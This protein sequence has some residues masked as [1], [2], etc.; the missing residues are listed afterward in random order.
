MTVH[1]H[2][3]NTDSA[4]PQRRTQT[5]RPRRAQARGRLLLHHSPSHS[6]GR[7]PSV[8]VG[9]V[10]VVIR[11]AHRSRPRLLLQRIRANP[12]CC[13]I[14]DSSALHRCQVPAVCCFRPRRI[15][16]GPICF[17]RSAVKRTLAFTSPAH[18]SVLGAQT[19]IDLPIRQE[20]QQSS[21]NNAKELQDEDSHAVRACRP[22][23]RRLR[24]EL[25]K[26]ARRSQSLP[27]KGYSPPQRFVASRRRAAQVVSTLAHPSPSGAD[28]EWPRARRPQKHAPTPAR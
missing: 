14:A 13:L 1:P 2:I 24:R 16:A 28:P 6:G 22:T 19:C 18:H 15:C 3:H 9:V 21:K 26:P 8:V 20:R 23:K 11:A 5:A 17:R 4:V 12:S 10:V 25:R 7:L 27:K